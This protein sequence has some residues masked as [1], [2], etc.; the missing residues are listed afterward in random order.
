MAGT[1]RLRICLIS[2]SGMLWRP[3][4]GIRKKHL[5]DGDFGSATNGIGLSLAQS[6]S[7]ASQDT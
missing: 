4:N 2:R 5:S 7:I 6:D 1:R 3:K